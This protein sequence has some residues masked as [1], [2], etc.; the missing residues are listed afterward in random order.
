MLNVGVQMIT[1]T[2]SKVKEREKKYILLII[3]ACQLDV[4]RLQQHHGLL[5]LYNQYV[6]CQQEEKKTVNPQT[7]HVCVCMFM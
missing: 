6:H 7:I 1:K 3:L 5:L 4:E 2:P